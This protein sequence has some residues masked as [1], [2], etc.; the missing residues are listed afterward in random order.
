MR[1][2]AQGKSNTG[3][4]AALVL[5]ESAVEKHVSSIFGK[6][7]SPGE[8]GHPPP[9]GRG[10]RVPPGV[11]GAMGEVERLLT[12]AS[13][14]IVPVDPEHADARYCLARVRRRAQPALG[15]RLRPVGRRHGAAARGPPAG[16]AVLRGLPAR[17]GDRLRRGQAPR[18]ARRPRSS[19][20]GSPRQRAG[21]GSAA[22]CSTTL[23]ACARRRRRRTRRASRPSAVL[24]EALALYRSTGWVEVPAFNDEPFADHWFEKQLP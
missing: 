3:I 19:G 11:S 23:E 6:L 16:R 18:P 4:A 21:S 20:C 10:A 8:D 9:G 2:M 5:S 12:A 1:E 15:A 13:V 17:R 14:E 7:G 22:A 24:T